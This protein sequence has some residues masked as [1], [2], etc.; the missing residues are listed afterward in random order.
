VAEEFPNG[1]WIT[2]PTRRYSWYW[3][4]RSA[5]RVVDKAIEKI[6]PP[7]QEWGGWPGCED[8]FGIF[9]DF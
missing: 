9:H 2:L 1:I 6:Y 8:D 4:G 3:T 5:N 7:C